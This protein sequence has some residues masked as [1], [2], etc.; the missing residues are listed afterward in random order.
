MATITFS[1]KNTA[2]LNIKSKLF[3]CCAM[4][5]YVALVTQDSAPI[6]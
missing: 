2:R 5:F 6:S 4:L 1:F 3:L